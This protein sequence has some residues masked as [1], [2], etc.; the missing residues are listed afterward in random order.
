M[1]TTVGDLRSPKDLWNSK[2]REDQIFVNKK[3]GHKVNKWQIGTSLNTDATTKVIAKWLWIL[4]II[5]VCSNVQTRARQ[6]ILYTR[7][8]KECI[9]LQGIVGV[10]AWETQ[11]SRS[12]WSRFVKTKISGEKRFV[13]IIAPQRAQVSWRPVFRDDSILSAECFLLFTI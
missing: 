10:L 2:I 3:T 9:N 8:R 13:K 11:D 5:R 4:K 6:C 7:A 1:E 12:L